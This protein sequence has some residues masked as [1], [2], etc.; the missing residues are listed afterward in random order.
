[1]GIQPPRA[2]RGDTS[3]GPLGWLY[4]KRGSIYCGPP[5]FYPKNN[6]FLQT[7]ELSG[8]LH[9]THLLCRDNTPFC[10]VIE[11]PRGG[12]KYSLGERQTIS[13]P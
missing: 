7:G 8:G 2:L 4:Q 11:Q 10:G 5:L 6:F 3:G 9:N 13:R 1:M 12:K